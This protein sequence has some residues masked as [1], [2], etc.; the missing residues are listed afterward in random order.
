MVVRYS[1]LWSRD[2][3]RGEEEGRKFRP[4]AIV[5]TVEAGENGE[6]VVVAPITHTPPRDAMNAL[7]I[8]SRVKQQLGL[9][10]DRAWIVLTEI[11]QFRWPGPDLY[12]VAGTDPPEITFGFLPP[13]LYRT[14]RT[15]IAEIVRDGN[16]TSVKRTE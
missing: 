9:D 2:S 1:Y 13:N 7:E 14:M 12:P 16:F 11:N 5:L 4:C 15:R 3:L 8:P 10:E 6:T